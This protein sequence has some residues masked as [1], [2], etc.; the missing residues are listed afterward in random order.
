MDIETFRAKAAGTTDGER[1]IVTSYGMPNYQGVAN[2]SVKSILSNGVRRQP[3]GH[4]FDDLST[5]PP[6]VAILTKPCGV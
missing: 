3:R 6:L 1:K 5:P 4:P 2:V